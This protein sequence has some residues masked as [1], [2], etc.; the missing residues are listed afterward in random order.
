M[1]ALDLS[2][3]EELGAFVYR[4]SHTAKLLREMKAKLEE[5]VSPTDAQIK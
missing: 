5:V 2:D 4:T 1:M 3:D